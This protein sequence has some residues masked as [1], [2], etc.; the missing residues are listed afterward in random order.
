MKI[1]SKEEADAYQRTVINGGIKGAAYGLAV[2]LPGTY[3]LNRRWAYY[4]SL[5]PSLK[6]LGVVTVAVPWCVIQAEREGMKFE[7]DQWHGEK[8]MAE[9]T[10]EE[11]TEAERW[12][13]LNT[14]EKALDWARRHRYGIVGTSWALGMAGSF[15]IIMRDP[16]QTFAQKIVQ[17]RMWAQGLTIGVLIASAGLS[18]TDRRHPTGNHAVVDHSWKTQVPEADVTT[19][20]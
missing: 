11:R 5:P 3:L 8:G 6:A 9:L 19:E 14:K 13:R 7:R 15:G 12:D 16:Y 20:K 10:L 18:A 4:R 17:A 2:S 1:I